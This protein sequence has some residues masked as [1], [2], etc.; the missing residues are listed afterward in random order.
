MKKAL[1]LLLIG[2]FFIIVVQISNA[3]VAVHF[4][5]SPMNNVPVGSSFNIDI[6]ADIPETDWISGFGLSLS[7]DLTK[8]ALTSMDVNRTLFPFD[9][10]GGLNPTV[11]PGLYGWTYP[12]DIHGDDILL[13]SLD[14]NCVGEGVSY[15]NLST[16]SDPNKPLTTPFFWSAALSAG[17]RD[18]AHTPGEVHQVSSPVSEPT[19]MLLLGSGLIGLAG[20]WRKKFFKK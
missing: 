4:N 12:G 17:Y 19:T 1:F 13:A 18:W 14:F 15:L 8:L 16:L 9:T 5:P 7:Y 10:A 6:L 2:C 3:D 11:I 20:Y